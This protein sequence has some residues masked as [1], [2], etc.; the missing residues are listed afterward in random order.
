MYDC[1]I[2]G[3]GPAGT[4]AAI[5]ASKS[6]N[7]VLLIEK[8]SHIGKKLLIS[9]GGRCN[10][11]NMKST[12]DFI[13]NLPNKNG[14]FLYS[15]LTNFSSSD[16]V[17]YFNALGVETKIEDN[18]R[19]FPK[20]NKAY[21]VVHALEKEL[22]KSHVKVNCEENVEKIT[23]T[24]DLWNVITNKGK[25]ISKKI[26]ITT[27]GVTYPQTGSTGD[28]H[29]FAKNF[30]HT[31]TALFPAETP[32]LS[33]DECIT[34]KE[35]QGLSMSPSKLSLTSNSGKILNTQVGDLIFTHFG[36]SGPCALRLSQFIYLNMLDN[37]SNSANVLVDFIPNVNNES[38]SIKLKHLRDSNSKK[39]VYTFLTENNIPKRLT[40]YI[41]SKISLI[42]VKICDLSNKKINELV[43]LIKTFEITVHGVKPLQK[44]FVTGGGIDIKEVNSKTMESKI[45]SGLYFAGEV[46]D[47]HGFTGGYNITIAFATGHL[48]GN[49]I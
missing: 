20:S 47:L 16:I 46:L 33:N 22:S 25:Y 12:K 41:I 6:G 23:I 39:L 10:I 1:I 30:D 42:D 48:A 14:K 37:N 21:D 7:K 13:S 3:A 11:T 43:D 45:L 35:L 36:L 5:T 40:N 8:N 27:G 19:V 9:G 28:G 17:E 34:S 49:S 26:I 29:V 15:A 32:L 2:V 38:L 18:D 4:I 24:N 44:A 31:I